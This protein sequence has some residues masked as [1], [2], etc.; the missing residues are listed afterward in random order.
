MNDAL[1]PFLWIVNGLL[2]LLWLLID[3]FWLVA[4]VP[5]LGYWV[6]TAPK[7]QQRWSLAIALLSIVAA[8]V[9]PFP[10]ALFL[11][12]MTLA[13]LL[14]RLLERLNP[15][16]THWNTLRAL[17]L[18]ALLGLAYAIYRSFILPAVSDPSVLQ[19]EGYLSAI[20]SIALYLLP[21]GFLALLAQGL[22]VHPPVQQ[23]A[24]EML[25]RFRSRG[26]P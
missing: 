17:G 19:A 5:T 21:I 8:A 24:D 3:S 7:D 20:A 6:W 4:L 26:K 23:P 13:G 9:S 2:A 25:F 1:L 18:Y 22:F 11:L 16:N 10:V 12:V 15:Q 14:A